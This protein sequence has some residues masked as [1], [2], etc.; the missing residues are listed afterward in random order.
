MSHQLIDTVSLGEHDLRATRRDRGSSRRLSQPE[1]D[2]ASR[3]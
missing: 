2:D 1:T 3:P